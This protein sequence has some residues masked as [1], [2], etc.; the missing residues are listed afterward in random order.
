MYV[1]GT[2]WK[3]TPQKKLK[4]G[5]FFS[6]S[7]IFHLFLPKMW[8]TYPHKNNNFEIVKDMAII[9]QSLAILA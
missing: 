2:N 9:S 7:L 6:F 4:L 5:N 8:V 3:I 1:S